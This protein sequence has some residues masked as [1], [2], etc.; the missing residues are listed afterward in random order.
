MRPLCR[1]FLVAAVTQHLALYLKRFR[2]VWIG[3]DR[4]VDELVGLFGFN[5]RQ[6]AG[7][8]KFGPNGGG[9]DGDRFAQQLF[10]FVA[11]A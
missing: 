3:C 1:T 2:R 11:V 4:F 6:Q 10:S 8:L 9:I 5:A 7:E